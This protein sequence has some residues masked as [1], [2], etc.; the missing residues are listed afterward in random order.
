MLETVSFLS[1]AGYELQK[2]M[3][4]GMESGAMDLGDRPKS[5]GMSTVMSSTQ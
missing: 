2:T 5:P 4:M 3:D 1:Y